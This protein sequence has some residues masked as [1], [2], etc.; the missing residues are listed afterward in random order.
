[1]KLLFAALLLVLLTPLGHAQLPEP[2]GG[3]IRQGT[4]PLRWQTGGPKCMEVPEWQIHEYNPDLFILR[5]SGCTD[6]EK[7]FLYLFFGKDKALL[8]DTGSG[9]PNLGPTLDRT[10]HNWLLRNGRTSIPLLVVHTHEHEDHTAGD[11]EVLAM[12]DPNI[13]VTLVKA[14]LAATKAFYHFKDWPNELTTI[15]LGGRV[16]DAIPIPG[17]TAAAMAFYDRQTAI[18]F[19]GDSCYPGRL[20]MDDFAAFQAS[21]E[22]MIKFTDGKLVSHLLGNHIEER[23]EAYSEYPFGTMYQPD[24]HTLELTRGDLLVLE[25]GLLS[26]H[27]K[28]GRLAMPDFTIEGGLLNNPAAGKEFET[29]MNATIKQQHAVMWDQTNVH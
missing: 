25:A 14:D 5:E 3:P 10:I 28:A 1:V 12:N 26:M 13:P 6:Y 11:P 24:E 21:T 9:K 19:P 23:R 8:L 7:P 22:R 20:F 18:L 2:D 27:G 16:I 17:H 4:L 29:H 15:D